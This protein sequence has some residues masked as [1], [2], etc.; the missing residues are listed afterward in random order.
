MMIHHFI[1]A[2]ERKDY[3]SM[4]YCFSKD[5]RLVD[6]SP[7]VVG[8]ENSFIYG[9]CAVDMFYHNKFILGGHTVS[10]PIIVNDH[11]ANFYT[12]YEGGA[13]VHVLATIE[14]YDPTT[15]LIKE[16]VIRPA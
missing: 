7:S 15:G 12:I 13:M 11:S 3:R 9:Q 4:A 1:K 2:L 16:M 10:D 14:S 5:C 8:N 6:Y